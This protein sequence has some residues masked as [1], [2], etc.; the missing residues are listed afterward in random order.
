MVINRETGKFKGG[1]EVGGSK[2]GVKR[3][4]KGGKSTCQLFL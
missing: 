2:E 4:T 1:K 3:R